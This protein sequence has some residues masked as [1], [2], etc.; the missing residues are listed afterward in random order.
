M[1]KK[2]TKATFKSLIASAL[3]F[4]VQAAYAQTLDQ[5]SATVVLL[6]QRGQ[7]RIKQKGK[8]VRED[9]TELGTG[10]FVADAVGNLFL[11]TAE[12]VAL[13]MKSDAVVTIQGVND[14]PLNY[15]IQELTGTMGI[16][17]VLHDSEDVA[18]LLLHPDPV[19]SSSLQHH[20]SRKEILSTE[21]AAP[22]R[23]RPVTTLGF[24]LGL[25]IQGH[26][27]PIS[28]ESR[29]A[30]GLVTLIS[31]T[32]KKPT[33]FFLLDNPSIG[34]FSGAPLLVLPTPYTSGGGLV[35]PH[36]GTGPIC[37]GVITATI[38]DETGGKMAAV[39]PSVYIVET[40]N[41]ATPAPQN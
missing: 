39:T 28:R 37:V 3:L 25:G 9:F 35:F 1:Q 38:S 26:F 23:D 18:V 4:V 13:D 8:Y 31:P 17:W 11:V 32:T 6:T 22:S 27:S 7:R 30:S 40:I 14:M 20:F 29:P 41:K 34:G 16:K 19:I 12:H 21:T 10:F 5:F 36:T 33:V 15:P 24:P 2:W